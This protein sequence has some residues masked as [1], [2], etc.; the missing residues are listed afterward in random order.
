MM[1]ME[2]EMHNETLY[3]ESYFMEVQLFV[4]YQGIEVD[5]VSGT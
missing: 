4:Q 3:G 2:N 5:W 1:R